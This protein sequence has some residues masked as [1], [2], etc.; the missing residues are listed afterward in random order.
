MKMLLASLLVAV[1]C[2][3][4]ATRFDDQP[5]PVSVLTVKNQRGEDATIYVMHAGIRGRRL[6]EV[7]SL[8]AAS[9]VLTRGDTPTASDVQ[10]L[11]RAM[12]TGIIEVSDPVN[13]STGANYE[14]KLG[15]G[16]GMAFLSLRYAGR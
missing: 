16:R 13:S 10:F 4:A 11:A 15:P 5:I 3:S 14:W 6:G 9:F 7:H 12:V 1:G 8:S 2:A